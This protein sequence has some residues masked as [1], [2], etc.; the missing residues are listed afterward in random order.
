METNGSSRCNGNG[1]GNGNGYANGE[2]ERPPHV[3]ML[4]TPGMGHLIPL[5]ELAKRLSSRHGLTSTLLTFASTASATQRAFLAS[6]PPAVSSRAL[7][8][9]DLSD[10]PAG[11]AIETRMS[12]ECARSVPALTAVLAD[13]RRTTRLVAFVADL[14]GADAFDAA[15]AAG[16]RRRCLFFPTNLHALTLILH[17]PDLDAKIPG[18][19]RDLPE[20]LRLPGCVPVPGPDILMPLQD[21]SDA[22]YRWMVHHGAKYRDADAVLVNSFDAVEPG[23]AAVLRHPEPGRPAVYPVGPLIQS[24]GGKGGDND[25]ACMEWL[26]RQPARSVVFVSFGSGGALPSEEMRELALGLEQ[27]GQRFLWV[28][29][30]PSDGGAVNDNYY[31]AESKRDPFA[32]L[33]EGFVHRTKGTGLLVPS[34]APQTRVLAHAATGGFLTHC[35]WN[36]VLESLAHG[37][38]MVAWPLYAEQRQNAVMLADGVGAAVRVPEAKGRVKIAAAVREVM[39]GAGRGAEVR[40]KVAELQKAAADG[41]KEGGNAAAA[42]AEVV[43][44]WMPPSF[45]SFQSSNCGGGGNDNDNDKVRSL[46]FVLFGSSGALPSD[47]MRELALRLEQSGQRFLWVVRSPISDGRT[48]NDNYYDAESKRHPFAYLPDGFMDRNWGVGM[49][50]RRGATNPGAGACRHG[51]VPHTLRLELGAGEPGAR[52]GHGGPGR[53]TPSSGRMR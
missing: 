45:S 23:P 39:V 20:P 14:F 43:G 44:T 50:G 48:V 19:F 11:S 52:R 2:D 37:V 40:K 46:V 35:G 8:P 15:R 9:V 30:S 16:V 31:D 3:A 17:L 13:L 10:L 7:P 4:A 33:P 27:S 1:N 51:R 36:S 49:R 38:P 6:L 12:E 28:V 24:G 34:W 29:R 5:A 21:K 53:S 22:C 47:E 32:Y 25:A 41:L 18:E 26:D 42:L